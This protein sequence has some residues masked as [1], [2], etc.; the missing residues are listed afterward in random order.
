MFI[1]NFFI[2]ALSKIQALQDALVYIDSV[3]LAYLPTKPYVY[4]SF[5]AAMKVFND[6]G[7]VYISISPFFPWTLINLI[8]WNLNLQ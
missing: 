7:Y 3:K 4:G 8:N 1:T 6:G 5:L 2:F